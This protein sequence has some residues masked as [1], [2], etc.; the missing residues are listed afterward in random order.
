MKWPVSAGI[1][2]RTDIKR[3][4]FLRG[5]T[6]TACAL[7]MMNLKYTRRVA[8]LRSGLIKR[9]AGLFV[10]CTALPIPVIDVNIRITRAEHFAFHPLQ[11]RL[12]PLSLIKTRN[13]LCNTNALQFN[14][15]CVDPHLHYCANFGFTVPYCPRKTIFHHNHITLLYRVSY[16]KFHAKL[17]L[18]L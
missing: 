16:L 15:I 12:S 13:L 11:S 7:L 9:S 3:I 14:K 18:K 17:F 10:P 4:G 5:N 1:T 8:N 2:H 6:Q